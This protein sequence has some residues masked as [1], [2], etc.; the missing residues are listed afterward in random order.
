MAIKLK[1]GDPDSIKYRDIKSRYNWKVFEI[2][3]CDCEFCTEPRYKCPY[4]GSYDEPEWINP[5]RYYKCK[6]CDKIGYIFPHDKSQDINFI[7]QFENE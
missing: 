5:Q 1:F 6:N 7:K 2:H 4:C 3:E